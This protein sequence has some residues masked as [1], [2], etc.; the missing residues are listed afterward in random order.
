MANLRPEGEETLGFDVAAHV[1][2]LEAHGVT[3]DVVLADPAA[4]DLGDVGVP[5]VR[6]ALAKANGLAHDPERLAV[7]LAGLVG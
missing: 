1:A 2:A 4:I 7:A 3:V 6:A 5:V